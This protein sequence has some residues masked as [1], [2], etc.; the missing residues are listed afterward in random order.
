[1]KEED[2]L[3]DIA[4]D[5]SPLLPDAVKEPMSNFLTKM[6]SES[7]FDDVNFSYLLEVYDDAA[8]DLLG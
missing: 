4:P 2:I 6:R 8:D 1:M 7:K 5:L 3:D